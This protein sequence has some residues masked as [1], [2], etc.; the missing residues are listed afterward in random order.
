[1]RDDTSVDERGACAWQSADMR[2]P[3]A[4]IAIW[5]LLH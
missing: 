1:M 3:A 5:S 2:M 4:A